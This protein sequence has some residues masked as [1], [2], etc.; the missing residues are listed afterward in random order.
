MAPR[1]LQA[2]LA[3]AFE[4]PQPGT[5]ED[6]VRDPPTD[7][8]HEGGES[9][10]GSTSH[11]WRTAPARVRDLRIYRVAISASPETSPRWG[12]GEALPIEFFNDPFWKGPKP[13]PDTVLEISPMG[14]K[15]FRV[16][17][18]DVS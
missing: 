4:V 1:R 13:T 17:V 15:T 5:A 2:G 16:M 6:Q 12:Q 14:G 11:S 10:L 8:A 7:S 9:E 3:M 18:K